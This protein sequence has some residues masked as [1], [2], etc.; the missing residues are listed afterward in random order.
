MAEPLDLSS[1]QAVPVAGPPEGLEVP[2]TMGDAQSQVSNNTAQER[3]LRVSLAFPDYASEYKYVYDNIIKGDE[4]LIR[5]ELA[6]KTARARS[7]KAESL[8]KHIAANV[9]GTPLTS[10]Q[11]KMIRDSVDNARK[12][13]TPDS[14][15]EEEFS[16][17]WLGQLDHTALKYPAGDYASAKNDLP[18]SVYNNLFD[19]TSVGVARKEYAESLLNDVSDM[20]K[21]QGWGGYA[22]DHLKRF[23]PGYTDVQLRGIAAG[24]GMLEG[25]SLG[26]NLAAQ[27]AHYLNL[28]FDQ[29]KAVMRKDVMDLAAANVGL[30]KDFAHAM[31]GL[32]TPES[33]LASATT[34]L[35]VSMIPGIKIGKALTSAMARRIGSYNTVRETLIDTGKEVGREIPSKAAM[36]E[37]SGDVGAAA[38]MRVAASGVGRNPTR[39]A[40]ETAISGF[41]FR[42]EQ[43]TQNPGSASRE[44]VTRIKDNLELAIKGLS[45]QL[46]EGS[47]VLRT[48]LDAPT[49]EAIKDKL[50]SAYPGTSNNISDIGAKHVYDNATNTHHVTWNFQKN[51]GEL[52]MRYTDA[53]NWAQ[54]HKIS[55]ELIKRKG[56][57]YYIEMFRPF[58]E[59]DDLVR[60]GLLKLP[61]NDKFEQ[62]MNRW[63]NAF[64]A[65]VRSPNDVQSPLNNWN[66]EIAT[67]APAKFFEIAKANVQA[68][69]DLAKSWEFGSKTRMEDWNRVLKASRT[70]PGHD[71]VPGKFFHTI[72]ELEDF[73]RT[74]LK[75]PPDDKEIAAY[76]AYTSQ[77][78]YDWALR[79]IAEYRHKARVGAEQHQFMLRA[80]GGNIKSGYVDG[81]LKH[82][83]PG[84][85]DPVLV[86]GTKAGD[87]KIYHGGWST[88]P[89]KLREKLT[90]EVNNGRQRNIE[91][92]D[93][94]SRPLNGFG[95]KIGNDFVR[96]VISP[97]VE[98][99][100]LN[101][102]QIARRE[103]GHFE[104]DHDFAVKQAK[105]VPRKTAKSV[106]HRYEGDE[107]A[108][109]AS[110][111]EMGRQFTKQLE[112]VR[113]ALRNG[114]EAAAKA[115]AIAKDGVPIEWEVVSSWFKA[116][117]K[118]GK[119]IA[120]RFSLDEPFV[121][122]GKGQTVLGMNDELI[123]RYPKTF[124]DA[125]REGNLAAQYNVEYTQAREAH[126]IGEVVNRGTYKEPAYVLEP[127]KLVDPM[128]IM[129]RSMSRMINSTFMDD[130]KISAIEH[131]I[132]KAK[133]FLDASPSEIKYQPFHYFN[134]PKWKVDAP[135]DEVSRLIAQRWQMNNFIG[136]PG[137]NDKLLTSFGQAL[138]DAAYK[139]GSKVLEATADKIASVR[140]PVAFLRYGTFHFKLGMFN[141]A[142]FLIQSQTYV[143]M[144]AIAGPRNAISG[145]YAT[146]LHQLS[147]ANK[148]P[149]IMNK[150]DEMYTRL[151]MP[152]MSR[153]K[154][155]ELKESIQEMEKTGFGHVG[156]EYA[157]IDQSFNPQL[158]RTG[159]SRFL[160]AG[161]MFFRSA[162]RNVRYGAWHIAFRE[163]REEFPTA[164]IGQ[165]ERAKIL[166]RADLL[167][168]N[169]SR[170]SQSI[171][172]K[173]PLSLTTQFLTYQMRMAELFLGK[174]LGETT[175]ERN[176]I[177]ARILAI[178]AMMY[179]VPMA[180]G[181]TGFPL[182]DTIRKASVQNGYVVGENWLRSAIEEGVLAWITAMAT[183][184][185]WD[186]RKGTWMSYGPSWGTQGLTTTMEALRS[187]KPWWRLVGGAA[188]STMADTWESMDGFTAA[189]GSL[190]RGD[191]KF[192]MK[193]EDGLDVLR[194]ISAFNKGTQVYKA[195]NMH[196][197]MSRKDIYITDT[198]LSSAVYMSLLGLHPTEVDDMHAKVVS[199]KDMKEEEKRGLNFFKQEYQRGLQS[200]RDGKVEEGEKFM[201]RAR[202][203]LE[204]YGYPLHKMGDAIAIANKDY[205][206]MV[207][208]TDYSMY[209]K[210]PPAG[211]EDEYLSTYQRAIKLQ[212]QRRGQ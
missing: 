104:H 82:S 180:A 146:F 171:L 101:Y 1:A 98:T 55:P 69:Q 2:T 170:A 67:Y 45:E 3:A 109:F 128:V 203:G 120:A 141:P 162:E 179:G 202:W 150:L 138:Q 40:I 61:V 84:G 110:N 194:S 44:L 52:W 188:F 70:L 63:I 118:G 167:N 93:T 121:L 58:N 148:N 4:N 91:L 60:D 191:G 134:S 90:E 77:M 195:W 57:G 29:Y 196:K 47:R 145:T 160:D 97:N 127:A 176:L 201:R 155:G 62:G 111:G 95:E 50:V 20:A 168:Q 99:K 53:Y 66:R 41:K 25:G 59:T 116:T 112:K 71:G 43:I 8:I 35:D 12:P 9:T 117:G 131:W 182:S 75:R 92:Y 169:M 38:V 183:G 166:D 181:V 137:F 94:V 123:K 87:E 42:L 83:V 193:I 22:W 126:G 86:T 68:V 154:P 34:P 177:R 210:N 15:I 165:L 89:K 113:V 88:I 28:P 21:N 105:V 132:Q 124:K 19:R 173:G 31:V 33:M 175:G 96:Y 106:E 129:N 204:L 74:G 30:A 26:A 56:A 158:V 100:P 140:D 186:S 81:V 208:Q 185:G 139:T 11:V 37:A 133:P 108:F 130:Y 103:G 147:R 206:S 115:V 159:V 198:T 209:I 48:N 14:I 23:L 199:V 7:Q 17:S 5:Q 184:E 200:Y 163:F 65:F 73:Y 205:E 36:A 114:D 122:V 152:G 10:E 174:R 144:L 164:I 161:T 80:P 192:E 39:D 49:I 51:D 76:F 143:T 125:T 107:T 142:Q 212:Q 151:R 190:I 13:P 157:L 189:M 46:G 102:V 16:K 119:K 156:G 207:N 187:D 211:K 136:T 32:S 64:T 6:A 149:E 172:N 54:Y 72:G 24:V 153:P 178:N 135:K 27:R 18:G 79:N 85:S 197:W 78:E